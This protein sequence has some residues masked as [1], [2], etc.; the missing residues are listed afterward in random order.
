M[1]TKVV[2]WI[3]AIFVVILIAS[4]QYLIYRQLK[5][6][7]PEVSNYELL[8]SID[9]LKT[10]IDSLKDYRDSLR[11]V[12]DTNKVKI[13]EVEKRYETIRDRI[14]TQSVDSDCTTFSN[15]LS[16]YQG[17]SSNNHFSAAK[18]N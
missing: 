16:N 7:L 11:S 9:S 14:I 15:Y 18:D 3:V 5:D 17:L 10:K 13:V 6:T 1:K 4:Q 2:I 8:Q 12:I